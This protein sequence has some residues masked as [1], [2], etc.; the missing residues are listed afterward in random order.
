VGAALALLT[1]ALSGCLSL[2]SNE[3]SQTTPG[4]VT[5]KAV[6]CASNYNHKTPPPPPNWTD[7]QEN[8]VVARDNRRSDAT[9]SGDGRLLVGFRIP[10]GADGLASFSN[11]QG[12]TFS[13]SES[14]TK[15]LERAFPPPADQHWI[16]YISGVGA[17]APTTDASKRRIEFQA[18]FTLPKSAG[19]APFTGQFRWREVVGFRSE[20]TPAEPVSCPGPADN[21]ICF[22]SPPPATVRTDTPTAVSDFGVLGGATTTAYAGTTAVVPF[23]L[24]YSDGARLGRKSFSLSAATD[25][26]HTTAVTEPRTI[27]VPPNSSNDAT[28]RVPVPA[29]TPPGQYTVTL[30]AAIGAPAV[31]RSNTA[32]IVVAPVPVQ[33]SGS[34]PPAP[35]PARVRNIWAL[36]SGRTTVRTLVVTDVPAGGTVTT[37]CRGRGCPPK[38]KASKGRRRVNLTPLFRRRKLRSGAVVEIRVGAPN[39]ISKRFT[40]TMH[41]RSLPTPKLRCVPPGAKK[42]LPCG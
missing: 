7:C 2:K 16:G 41:K 13:K 12:I 42:T 20:N 3:A 10:A 38:S 15:E 9:D 18:D 32:R 11:P 31:T 35:N 33:G 5:L 4:K 24:R 29:N 14:Y 36:R 25:L 26:P 39:Y 34:S 1:V 27:A 19:G 8:N 22:D 23:S 30:S 17:Y 40:F 6:V 37:T 28:T 21:N